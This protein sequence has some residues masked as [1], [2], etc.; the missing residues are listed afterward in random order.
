MISVLSHDLTTIGSGFHPSDNKMLA[1]GQRIKLNRWP[2]TSDFSL[3]AVHVRY[4]SLNSN[5]DRSPVGIHSMSL[6]L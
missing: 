2:G 4:G 3:F 1:P 6:I 5:K